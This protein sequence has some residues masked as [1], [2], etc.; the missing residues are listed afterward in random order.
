MASWIKERAKDF[1]VGVAGIADG[2]ASLVDAETGLAARADAYLETDNDYKYQERV[3]INLDTEY[4]VS[5]D[6]GKTGLATAWE[7]TEEDIAD[8]LN[9]TKT[10]VV[11]VLALA[12][13]II[14]V[15]K[16]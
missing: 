11:A 16:L 6:T 3:E 2:A 9:T 13:G 4:T 8:K 7:K 10:L 5:P 15:S 12:A 14:I 1:V